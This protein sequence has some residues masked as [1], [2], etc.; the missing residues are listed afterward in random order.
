MKKKLLLLLVLAI[1]FIVFTLATVFMFKKEHEPELKILSAPTATVMLDGKA[2]GKTPIDG[3]VV[4]AGEHILRLTPESSTTETASWQGKVS[5][6]KNSRT[7][8][9]RA[10]GSS[11]ITSSGVVFSVR[12]SEKAF[13]KKDVGAIELVTDPI[14]TIIYLDNDEKGI[15][16]LV[17]EDVAVG[18]HEIS[19]YSPGFIRRSQKVKVEEGYVVAG[20]IKLAIDPSY[21]KVADAT[22]TPNHATP[23]GTLTPTISKTS[24]KSVKIK[25]TPTGFLR[26][27]ESSSTSGAEVGRVTPGDTFEIISEENGWIQIEY[28]KGKEGWISGQ[29]VE[30]L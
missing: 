3:F 13:S 23:S 20:E 24:G 2:I 15:A 21:Q 11:D 22:P 1:G 10:L 5:A 4:S 30:R 19:A 29:Y 12:K 9:D 14:G 7:Y 16:P 26:V 28:E 8:V 27:R 17:L 6:Y 25:D 18:E